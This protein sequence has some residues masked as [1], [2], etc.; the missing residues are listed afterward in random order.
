MEVTLSPLKVQWILVGIT[1]CKGAENE[2]TCDPAGCLR[3]IQRGW[4]SLACL[5]FHVG[6]AACGR[7]EICSQLPTS[8][9]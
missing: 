6:S 7:P 5:Y 2:G 9:K 4:P 3:T 1:T 8:G